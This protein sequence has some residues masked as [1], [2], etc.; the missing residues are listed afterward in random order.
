MPELKIGDTVTRTSG[1]LRLIATGTIVSI[2][3]RHGPGRGN[4][5]LYAVVRWRNA[6]RSRIGAT[7]PDK[8]GRL[9]LDALKLIEAA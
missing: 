9:R 3:R 1:P 4:G 8:L 2:Y 5:Q 7:T 6:N